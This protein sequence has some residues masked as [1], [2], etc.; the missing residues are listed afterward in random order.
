MRQLQARDWA[1]AQ[2]SALLGQIGGIQG[3]EMGL[4]SPAQQMG[5]IGASGQQMG[6][7]MMMQGSMNT[8]SFVNSLVGGGM[9]GWAAGG[10]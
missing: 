2:R 3:M 4:F 6:A 8:Q 9:M 1:N 10:F 5:A 7:Q